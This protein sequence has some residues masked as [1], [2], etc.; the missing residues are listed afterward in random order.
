MKKRRSWRGTTWRSV[1]RNKRRST[2]PVPIESGATA[3]IVFN[4]VWAK[5]R[6][7]D[8]GVVD[9]TYRLLRFRPD[10]YQY[11]TKYRRGVW[12]GW[13][14]LYQ[15]RA[16]TF[17]G[18]LVGRVTTRLQ[19]LDVDVDIEDRA[20]SPLKEPQLAGGIN[21]KELRPYQV[22]AADCAMAARNGVFEAATG[23]GKTEI[24]AEMIRRTACRSLIIVASRD[25]AWQTI[26]RFAGSDREQQTLE[27]PNAPEHGLYGIV[28]DDQET[29]GLVTA[30]LYQTL[31]RRLMPVCLY[32]DAQG[33]LH[34]RTCDVKKGGKRCGGDLDFTQ[35][36][37]VREWLASF[38]A[39]HLD[40]CHRAPAK[41]W[42]PVVNSCPAY[43][44]FGYSATPF[45]SDPITEL[46]LVGATG[47]IMY[48]FPAREAI[49]Q[50]YLTKPFVVTVDPGFP[51]ML[52][53]GD[54]RYIDSYRDGIVEHVK[55]NRLIAEIAKG[56]SEGWSMSTLILVQWT[57]HGRNIKRA[58]REIGVRAE[59]ISGTAPTEK[60]RDV[61]HAM[62][63]GRLNCVIA[64]TI[65]DE[66]VNVPAIGALILAGG[67][68]ARHKVVQR[69]GRGL[70]VVEGKKYLAV[71]D[72][73]DSHGEKY[74]VKHARQR[75]RAVKDEGY[76]QEMLTPK[77]VKARI[78]KG[79]VRG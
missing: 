26:E 76:A 43:W 59:F 61:M 23:T 65:F 33:E 31:V 15:G 8:P 68:K 24:M 77:Q 56:T 1:K 71:F 51:S 30:A 42:W 48:S 73:W 37:V 36:E 53:D 35:T 2:K 39:I 72:I 50:G 64:T 58:L 17:P 57:E 49:E 52:D 34:Q 6:T 7:D 74:L 62:D 54:T 22:E 13:V 63:D 79:D 27:F 69:I 32:C 44:R 18:G 46:K 21:L 40:E 5:L 47:E 16:G 75:L 29:P 41:T 11:M 10:G 70:R 60:R 19:E 66:G 38:D 55:R 28:G 45:K 9:A 25:L 67:G 12:D 4:E 78:K 3:R 20:Q 14:S